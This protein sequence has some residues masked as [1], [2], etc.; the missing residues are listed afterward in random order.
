MENTSFRNPYYRCSKIDQNTF[1]HLL[2]CFAMDLT[3]TATAALVGVS[4][5]STNQLFIRLREAIARQSELMRH[6]QH[7]QSIRLR[8]AAEKYSAR[9]M[10][11]GIHSEDG[12]IYTD[13][14]CDTHH[15][16][17]L[18][19][20]RGEI[21]LEQ[22]RYSACL[23]NHEAIVDTV[24]NKL[25]RIRRIQEHSDAIPFRISLVESF[26]GYSKHR[27]SKF[28]EFH[29]RPIACIS[30]KASIVSTIAKMSSFASCRLY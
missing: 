1:E 6:G 27:V 9:P 25:Y 2:R 20:I 26:W 18:S 28:H 21:T 15:A 5:R 16:S 8:R 12:R 29:R 3:A 22:L 19:L 10:L 24:Q 30:K 4:I 14:I 17:L 11:F 13:V 23:G 7:M